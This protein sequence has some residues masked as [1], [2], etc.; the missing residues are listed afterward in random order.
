M[1]K[2]EK[3]LA[4]ALG[5]V[6]LAWIGVPFLEARFL[7]PL[8][9]LEARRTVLTQD[10]ENAFDQQK[11]LARKDGELKDWRARSL[12]PD[13]LDAQRL[14]QEWLT[15]LAQLS[16]FEQTKIT[17]DRRVAEADTYVTIPVTLETKAKLQELSQF[18]DWFRSVDL[19]HRIARLDVVSP[20]NEGNPE[21]AVTLTAEGLSLRSAPD[22]T[23][24]FP[25]TE[26]FEDLAKDAQQLTVV[27]NRGFPSEVP[28]RVRIGNEFLNVTAVS[29]NTWSV[30]RGIEKTFAEDHAANASIEHFPLRS[31]GA[32]SEEAVS[33]MWS[34]SLFTKPAPQIDY[35]P[36]LASTSPPAAIRGKKWSWKLEIAG[37][38]PAFGTPNFEL[39]SAPPGMNL[40][41]RSGS[42]SWEV[43]S[44]TELGEHRIEVLVWGTN[45]RNAGFTPTVP[46]RVRDVNQPPRID[47]RGPLQFFIGRESR[48][49]ITAKDPDG[50]ASKLKYALEEGP[51]GLTIDAST[52]ELRWTPPES[53]APQELAI[54]IK[55]TDA[56]ELPESE[57]VRIPVSLQEDSARYAYL[58][59]YVQRTSGV[60]EAWIYDRATNRR[61]VLHEGDNFRIADFDL[62]VEKIGPTFILVKRFGQTYRLDFEQSLVQMKPVAAEVSEPPEGAAPQRDAPSVPPGSPASSGNSPLS[63]AAPPSPPE[64]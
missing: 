52:G 25:Q 31:V 53:L 58:T 8:K 28:F 2:R 16:G 36:R 29:G 34:R 13:P 44:G 37:W 9:E 20:A 47:Q 45:G 43:G 14:Y 57:T 46:V 4:I 62:T 22:R 26:L 64:R 5:G 38:N 48:I 41:E 50:D 12:P 39:L 17:L 21:L 59:G 23:R 15:N 30:Q 56:D 6:L 1:Q 54:T 63:P 11:A 51:E 7:A 61:T 35:Q 27:S 40:D 32:D 24:L 33:G 3:L 10:I 60:K 19:L 55:V 18:L 49:P 42:L